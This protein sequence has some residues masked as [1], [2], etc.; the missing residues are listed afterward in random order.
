MLHFAVGGGKECLPGGRDEA[1][2]R[3]KDI[4]R[5]LQLDVNTRF[6]GRIRVRRE[7]WTKKL[8]L[9]NRQKETGQWQK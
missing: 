2:T 3:A 1:E 4:H 9:A 5:K 6:F 7:T 8:T